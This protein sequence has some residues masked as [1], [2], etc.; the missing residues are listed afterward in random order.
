MRSDRADPLNAVLIVCVGND[1]VADD[2]VG[3]QIF[4][5][6]MGMSFPPEVRLHRVGVGGL[7]LLEELH[8]EKLLVV[9]DAVHF[10]ALPGTVHVLDWD[11]LAE[12][13]GPPVTSHGIGLREVIGICRALYPEKNPGRVVLV[14]IEGKCFNEMGVPMT[15]EVAAAVGVAIE[16]IKQLIHEFTGKG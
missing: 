3:C 11:A 15:P 13:R 16:K 4:E 8:G 2:A 7:A 10:G 14:G 1:L 6:L 9:V 5:R 12:D